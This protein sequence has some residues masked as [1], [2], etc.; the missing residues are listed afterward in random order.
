MAAAASHQLK[1]KS[2][3]K[4]GFVHT[5][6]TTRPP[7]RSSDDPDM[8]T[9]LYATI[10]STT[11]QKYSDERSYY[12]CNSTVI[13][14]TLR[15]SIILIYILRITSICRLIPHWFQGWQHVVAFRVGGPLMLQLDWMCAGR[16][17][18]H[19]TR[20]AFTM[21]TC[22]LDFSLRRLTITRVS[23][24]F[25]M[26]ELMTRLMIPLAFNTHL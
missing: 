20:A 21:V 18:S 12:Y 10:I 4:S 22:F 24:V 26:A 23:L 14:I 11:A 3:R 15:Y 1:A 25:K 6:R 8:R 13:I 2:G 5:R 9:V 19:P 17:S 7:A 16:T